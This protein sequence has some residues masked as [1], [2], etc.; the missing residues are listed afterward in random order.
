[1][2]TLSMNLVI[3]HRIEKHSL[4]LA[5][6]KLAT[7]LAEDWIA[8][9]RAFQAASGKNENVYKTNPQSYFDVDP[10]KITYP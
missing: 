8:Q 4:K 2:L 6:Y 10:Q 9:K 3:G 5:E 1:M 7:N